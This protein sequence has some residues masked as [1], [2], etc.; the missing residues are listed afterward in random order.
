MVVFVSS[1]LPPEALRA[2]DL[3]PTHLQSDGASVRTDVVEAGPQHLLADTASYRPL[4][5]G[6]QIANSS[7]A[8]GTLGGIVYD[9]TDYEVVMLTC[10]HV[11]TFPGA[12]SVLPGNTGMVQPAGGGVVGQSK[13]IVPW[14]PP[15]L[16]ATWAW[17]A[18]VDAGIVSIDPPQSAEFDVIGLGRQPFVVLPPHEGLEVA[19]RGATSLLTT[20]A[21]ETLDTWFRAFDN[22]GREVRIGGLDSAFS[23]RSPTG[24]VFALAGDSGSL[25]VDADGSA[26][27]GLLFSSD[28]QPGGISFA[29][30][31]GAAMAALGLEVPC[32]GALHWLIRRALRKRTPHEFEAAE[33]HFVGTTGTGVKNALVAA[34]TKTVDR[35]RH[36]FL[37]GETGAFGSVVGR[38]LDLLAAELA[39]ALY[40]DH[41]VAG[42]LDAAF[43]DWLIEPTVYDMLEYELP[44]TFGTLVIKA[45]EHLP[46]ASSTE[47]L[48]ALGPELS[49]LGGRKVRDVIAAPTPSHAGAAT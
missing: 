47:A 4:R 19:K 33:P 37:S 43:G 10:N 41:D 22:D 15:A 32:S 13:R 20:G 28:L 2:S 3:V 42:L 48:Q 35:F 17:E 49:G 27:R 1:K 25:V 36:D 14:L 7:G 30:D 18:Q 40:G 23:V 8:A 46:E 5:G 45:L 44:G 16:G 39:D 11:V 12:R 9:S 38:T 29:S 26:A 21:V 24:A 6:C 31:L 34:A